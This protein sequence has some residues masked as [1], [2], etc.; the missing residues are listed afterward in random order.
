MTHIRASYLVC[1]TPRAASNFQCEVLSSAGV[2]GHPDEYFW[3]CSY[4]YEHWGVADFEAFADRVREYG[5]TPNGKPPGRGSGSASSR[6]STS[7]Y[8]RSSSASMADKRV[9]L[10]PTEPRSL[11]RSKNSCQPASSH[12]HSRIRL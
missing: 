2:A 8:P 6:D 9:P 7:M 5:T 11:K 12:S 4:W 1:T 10:T 3:K